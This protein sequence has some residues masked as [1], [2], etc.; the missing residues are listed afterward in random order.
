MLT[1]SQFV[2]HYPRDIVC[3]NLGNKQPTLFYIKVGLIFNQSY[4][5]NLV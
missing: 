1:I 3:A 4:V 2:K 5:Y